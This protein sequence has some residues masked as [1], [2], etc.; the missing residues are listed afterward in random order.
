MPR[1][2]IDTRAEFALFASSL[3]RALCSGSV[4]HPGRLAAFASVRLRELWPRT[5][6][7]C[8]P[9][10]A[11]IADEM[12]ELLDGLHALSL[13]LIEGAHKLTRSLRG[14]IA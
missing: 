3:C 13:A 5:S 2:Q 1:A 10:F 7:N 8:A 14:T 11:E 12:P 4:V 6:A 9:I